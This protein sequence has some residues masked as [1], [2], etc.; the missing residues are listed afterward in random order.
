MI[1]EDT[2]EQDACGKVGLSIS[3]PLLIVSP[4]SAALIA[5]LVVLLVALVCIAAACSG[6]VV[7]SWKGS[8]GLRNKWRRCDGRLAF[9]FTRI[10]AQHST[11][12][13]RHY[14]KRYIG[15]ADA[16]TYAAQYSA[17][18]TPA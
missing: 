4:E 11:L 15:D 5:L 6:S 10:T 3:T 1:T 7:P 12:L 17:A 14:C 2:V 13:L 16:A 8:K 9:T 18:P